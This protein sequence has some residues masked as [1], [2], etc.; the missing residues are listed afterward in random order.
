MKKNTKGRE[1]E[2]KRETWI[3]RRKMKKKESGRI[4]EE[5]RGKELSEKSVL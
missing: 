1:G 3:E 5:K 4:R 2:D